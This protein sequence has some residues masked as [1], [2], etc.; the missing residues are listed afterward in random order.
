MSNNLEYL[1]Y[2]DC[3]HMR[4]WL[5]RDCIMNTIHKD[6]DID[7]KKIRVQFLLATKNESPSR[8]CFRSISWFSNWVLSIFR[9]ASRIK[10][11]LVFF[12]NI[13]CRETTSTFLRLS[14]KVHKFGWDLKILLLNLLFHPNEKKQETRT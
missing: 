11:T 2:C 10:I 9:Q 4:D 12:F 1:L 3:H 7:W 13:S 8:Y 14:I 6:T 5:A